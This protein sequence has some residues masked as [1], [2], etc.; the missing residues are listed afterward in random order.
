MPGAT[1]VQSL[2][3]ILNRGREANI[4]KYRSSITSILGDIVDSGIFCGD[5]PAVASILDGSHGSLLC[6]DGD[7]VSLRSGH[8]DTARAHGCASANEETPSSP[9]DDT[10]I[11]RYQVG[12][13][14]AS[15]THLMPFKSSSQASTLLAELPLESR[16]FA[17]R[18]DHRFTYSVL[19]EKRDSGGDGG[20]SLVV[21]MDKGGKQTKVL[22]QR[23]W[24]TCL[25]LVNS[26]VVDC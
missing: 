9:S 11:I 14:C 7:N 8:Y 10:P 19:V 16:L 22:E 18:S 1:D 24:K 25:R 15:Q 4:I 12:D 6:E 23:H 21:A 26:G 3:A 5:S 13:T 17:R 20:T 2:R